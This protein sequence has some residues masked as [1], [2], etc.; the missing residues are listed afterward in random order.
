MSIAKGTTVKLGNRTLTF[1]ESIG[2]IENSNDI[3]NDAKACR[4]RLARDGYL[5]FKGFH[6]KEKVLQARK[7]LIALA[8]AKGLLKAGSRPEDALIGLENKATLFGHDCGINQKT[9][10][11]KNLPTFIEVVESPKVTE[12]F[13]KLYDE[14]SQVFDHHWVRCVPKDAFTGFHYDIIYMGRGAQDVYSMWTPFGDCPLEQGGLVVCPGSHKYTRLIETYG[15]AD[16]DR[17]NLGREKDGH[18]S[19]DPFEVIEKF[20][21][22]LATTNYEAGD[23]MIFGMFFLHASLT[24]INDTYRFSADVRYQRSSA[25]KDERWFGKNPK[26]HYRWGTPGGKTMAEAKSHW[27]I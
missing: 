25:P 16:V 5:F 9:F 13:D 26:G 21:A 11:K 8:E 4:E 23:V 7:E 27:G 3:V 14:K 12:F 1:G 17:D 10:M 2:E 20:G 15:T 18:I 22:K 24:N 6:D 19:K